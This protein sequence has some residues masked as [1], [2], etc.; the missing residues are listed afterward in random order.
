MQAMPPSDDQK[1][2][3]DT[4]AH[5]PSQAN[6]SGESEPET[7]SHADDTVGTGTSIALGCIA[8]TIVLIIIGL[9]FVGIAALF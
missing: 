3:A 2:V 8:G 1:I 5:P 9:I 4:T 7:A 6:P